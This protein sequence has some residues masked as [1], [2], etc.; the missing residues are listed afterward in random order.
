M[1]MPQIEAEALLLLAYL[2]LAIEDLNSET[3]YLE[4]R[5]ETMPYTS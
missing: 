2:I 3:R 4:L 5:K 1:V